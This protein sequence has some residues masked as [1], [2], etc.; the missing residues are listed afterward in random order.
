MG[1]FA[2]IASL[3]L[4]VLLWNRPASA[5]GGRT[6]TL[7]VEIISD[8]EARLTGDARLALAAPGCTIDAEG[9]ALRTL[10]CPLG[11]ADRVLEATSLGAS[12][13]IVIVNIVGTGR[14]GERSMLTPRSPALHLPALDRGPS[15]MVV[16]FVRLGA[17]HV[18]SGLD[19]LLFLVALF[20]QAHR[21]A[22]GSLRKIATELVPTATA[23]TVAH[24]L[25]LGATVLGWLQVPSSVAEALIAASLVLVALDV[26]ADRDTARASRLARV[27]LTFAFGLVHGLGFAGALT[28]PHLPEHGV[29]LALLSF[30]AGVELG[31]AAALAACIFVA[32]GSRRLLAASPEHGARARL[33]SAYAVGS[34]GVAMFLVRASALLRG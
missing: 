29:V 14:E 12:T 5:H 33:A 21:A 9:S 17:E 32:L 4:L 25:T 31:Q 19:H 8:T 24:S 20:W 26:P 28:G 23:F 3:V 2:T 10:R 30:N 13:D 7:T 16:R 34:I 18:L 27:A 11:L 1:A 22:K 6:S 15:A